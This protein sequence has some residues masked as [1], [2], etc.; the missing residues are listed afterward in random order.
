M[1]QTTGQSGDCVGGFELLELLGKGGMGTVYRARSPAGQPVAIKILADHLVKNDVLRTRF[2]LEAKLAM[3]IEHPNIVRALLVAEENGRHYLV[4][5]FVDGESL[6]RRVQRQGRLSEEEAIPI[7]CSVARA[8]DK[9]HAEGLVHRDVK[10]ENI[11]LG[12]DGVAKLTDLGL[13]KKADIDLDLTR[14]GRGLGTPHYMAPEQFR[15]AKAVTSKSDIYALG[16]TIYV[17]VTGRVPFRGD[18]PLDTFMKKT[19]NIYTPVREL[20]PEVGD[21]LVHVIETSMS[22]DPDKRPATAGV[23]ADYLEGKHRSLAVGYLEKQL[24]KVVEP[25]WY[26]KA[27]SQEQ[28]PVRLR[29]PLA[30]IQKQIRKGKI[31]PGALASQDKRGP[32]LPITQIE[33]FREDLLAAR[34]AAKATLL[35]NRAF[36]PSNRPLSTLTRLGMDHPAFWITIA[37]GFIGLVIIAWMLLFH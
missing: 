10:P 30:S 8:L 32:F 31:G 12:K 35:A 25:T 6:G 19:K 20:A 17:M 33:A 4:M 16:A 23:I 13:A 2:Y 18:G 24:V 27:S 11:L 14:T 15:N 7:A 22:N 37:A 26:V 21:A 34:P 28:G 29:G 5:E 9:A 3:S 36:A 1:S